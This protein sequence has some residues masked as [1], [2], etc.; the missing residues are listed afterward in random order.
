MHASASEGCTG[1]P[2][3]GASLAALSRLAYS[4]MATTDPPVPRP[5]LSARGQRRQ[6]GRGKIK[7]AGGCGAG[8]TSP[9][10]TTSRRRRRRGSLH[11]PNL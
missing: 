7:D 3:L 4:A 5:L 1:P 2:G 11:L 6:R 9:A 8:R 10:R